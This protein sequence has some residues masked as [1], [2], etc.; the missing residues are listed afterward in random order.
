MKWSGIAY[1]IIVIILTHKACMSAE[2]REYTQIQVR[3]CELA[4]GYV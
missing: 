2:I 3:L 1:I 4:P